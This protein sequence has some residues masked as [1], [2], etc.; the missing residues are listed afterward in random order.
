MFKFYSLFFNLE[1]TKMP[2]KRNTRKKSSSKAKRQPSQGV[3]IFQQNP[4]DEVEQKKMQA[5]MIKHAA[6]ELK[7]IPKLY[8][9]LLSLLR[10]RDPLGLIG[11][12][13]LY[14]LTTFSSSAGVENSEGKHGILPNHLEI[15]QSLL[16][17]LPKEEW[18]VE[19]HLPADVQK[20]F[21]I[22]P[23]LTQLILFQQID[24]DQKN[25]GDYNIELQSILLK[26]RQHTFGVRNWGYYSHVIDISNE[27]FLPLDDDMKKHYGFGL[28]DLITI[29]KST[30]ELLED[31]QS[32]HL[33]IIKSFALAKSKSRMA[34]LYFENVKD[35]E[36]SPKEM[37]SSLP[38]ECSLE[39]FRTFLWAHWDLRV[40]E[41]ATFLTSDLQSKTKLDADVVRKVFNALSYKPNDL[42]GLNLEY[43]SLDNPFWIRPA[44]QLEDDKFYI[45]MPQAT[46]SHIHTIVEE[47]AKGANIS[48]KLENRRSEY[49]ELKTSEIFESLFNE[50]DIRTSMKWQEEDKQWEHDLVAVVDR[51][52]FVVEAKSHK[53]TPSGKRGSPDRLKRHVQD[54]IIESSKQSQRLKTLLSDARA[55][56][57]I[58]VEI[59]K[60]AK[61]DFNSVDYVIRIST[62]LSDLTAII[63]D[64]IDFQK[65]GW[66]P[67]NTEL[68]PA[69]II[70][71]LLCIFHI[72]NNPILIVHYLHERFYFQKK[73]RVLGD[74]LDVLGLYLENGLNMS[75]PNDIKQIVITGMSSSID[76]YF[77]SADHN[78]H[79]PKPEVVMRPFFRDII[80]EL[81]VRKNEGWLSAGLHLL[82]SADPNE[83]KIAE[84]A[85]KKLRK[86]V[87]SDTSIC[88]D[89]ASLFIKQPDNHK[90]L[91]IFY[92]FSEENEACV[93]K[94][95]REVAINALKHE[96]RHACVVF[97]RCVQ[98]WGKP[99]EALALVESDQIN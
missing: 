83:Q 34:D 76:K 96:Q 38:E 15:L 21:D 3:S 1:N 18:G 55:G 62:T 39:E 14:S 61:L 24:S 88:G 81:S 78:I 29:M 66:L 51:V 89:Q 48:K 77:M 75:I 53:L 28:S 94:Y 86:Q 12:I 36:G 82:S 45:P 59:C 22:L 2:R 50:V 11:S 65:S 23:K 47:L 80:T 97:G 87:I 9:E 26:M 71:D 70:S 7:N 41:V 92:L 40:S 60:N 13:A 73:V 30:V 27:L 6:N 98:R 17:T 10:S 32:K 33:G 90:A 95:M 44:I 74:E 31:N 25:L 8:E 68:A 91:V 79:L 63:L 5:A 57:G 19:P 54:I 93:N 42:S 35:L 84:K 37:V 49:L 43:M 64:E 52:L 69:I 67:E 4:I 58:A 16:L 20:L 72:L 85:L 46:F 99:F 56:Q